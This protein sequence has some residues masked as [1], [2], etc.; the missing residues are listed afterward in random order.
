MVK[1]I[2]TPGAMGA[3]QNKEDTTMKKFITDIK[4][5]AALL[6]AG[7]A[8]SACSSDDNTIDNQP[9]TGKYTLTVRATKSDDAAAVKANAA[10][11]ALSLSLDGSTLSASWA[12]GEKVIVYKTGESMFPGTPGMP[13]LIGTLEPTD[14]N[15]TDCTLT[16]DI[17]LDKAPE[18][19]ETLQLVFP[20]SRGT[21]DGAGSVAQDGTLATIQNY[22][23]RAHA[24][25]TVTSVNGTNVAAT[26]ATFE[27]EKAIVKFVLKNGGDVI[28][29]TSVSVT[30]T[31]SG[32]TPD[33][34]VTFSDFASTYTAN[35][36]CFF[37]AISGLSGGNFSGDIAL[38]ATDGTYNYS[39]SKSDVNFTAGK[40]YEI[41]VKMTK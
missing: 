31:H 39:Y 17:D 30:L 1:R 8:F 32:Y 37:Y 22:F 41:T 33:E 36:G 4:T 2:T 28:I 27:N 34:P 24:E 16:G 18:V 13:V 5:L 9:T 7:A 10:T 11:R 29:P 20:G 35:G 21:E 23:D 12:E 3:M 6:I 25:V 40:Y 19:N 26:A 38:E 14:I 15:G